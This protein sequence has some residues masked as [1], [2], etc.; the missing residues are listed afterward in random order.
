MPK[1]W[2]KVGQGDFHKWTEP[3]DA[4]EGLWQ[5]Q[6][7]GQYGPLGMLDQESGKRISF[8]LH[9]AL[10]QRVEG[11]RKGAEVRI[12]YLGKQQ[13]KGGREFK[14]FDLFVANPQTDLEEPSEAAE[15]LPF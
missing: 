7:D 6:R 9:T 1:H 12:V 10:L 2:I 14:A 5:G 13:S 3:G 11:L 8:P 4:V 15:D